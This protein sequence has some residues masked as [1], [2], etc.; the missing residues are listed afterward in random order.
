[1]SA[2]LKDY[3]IEPC[4][5]SP[6]YR[7][8][9][10][11]LTASRSTKRLVVVQLNPSTAN[12]T[13]SDP[14]I[15]KVS[16]W[17][18]EHGF[19]HITFLNLFA[20]RTPYPD[21]LIGQPYEVLVGTRNDAVTKAAFSNADNVIFAWGGLHHSIE[22]HYQLR[23]SVLKGLLGERQVHAVGAPVGR[24]FPRHG[25][26][27]NQSNRQMRIYVWNTDNS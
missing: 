5:E 22:D 6:G 10:D 12:T 3:Q 13:K 17:A 26:G 1:M 21:E 8:R 25:R 11:V 16:F 9:L 2:M 7:Y 4:D 19:R 14:T 23:L 24:R 27:W 15:G 20:R 18:L